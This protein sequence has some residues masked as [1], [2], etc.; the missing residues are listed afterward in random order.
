[1]GPRIKILMAA[2][3]ALGVFVIFRAGFAIKSDL[4][5]AN[6]YE[7]IKPQTFKALTAE[8]LA[9]IDSDKD[10][11]P[12]IN[13]A[14]YLT[15]PSNPDTDGDGYKDGEELVSGTDPTKKEI[16]KETRGSQNI[17][18]TLAHRVAAGIVAGDL[19]P[20]NEE[21]YFTGM[22]YVSFAAIDEALSLLNPPVTYESLE[23]ISDT[24]SSKKQYFRDIAGILEGPFLDLFFEQPRRLNRATSLMML[25]QN[26]EAEKIFKDFYDTFTRAHNQLLA[27]PVP[28]S[29]L[30]FHQELV[31][32][33]QRISV[34]YL[35]LSKNWADP[36][37][38]LIALQELQNNLLGI[39][40]SLIQD[41]QLKI[42]EEKIELPNSRLYNLLN[43]LNEKKI[44]Q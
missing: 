33:V 17:T 20:K 3:L 11:I 6:V 4:G 39:D 18:E 13:E 37:L 19:S 29:W 35:A 10:G 34:N 14:R 24:D 21:K 27:I 38:A 23:T 8:D 40:V 12:D 32:T 1:M 25:G 7:A 5:K 30:D 26:G 2:V 41:F 31:R 9:K 42:M 16:I 43:L 28:I 36:V 44:T 15:D 22:N